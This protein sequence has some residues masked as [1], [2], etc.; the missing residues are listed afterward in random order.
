MKISSYLLTV[1]V[2]VLLALCV[3]VQ[4]RRSRKVCQSCF[5]SISFKLFCGIVCS[6]RFSGCCGRAGLFGR[7]LVVYDL[8][9][10]ESYVLFDALSGEYITRFRKNRAGAWRNI[11]GQLRMPV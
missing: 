5:G 6:G 9:S 1:V 7:N 10:G 11:F 3:G 8:Q 2:G 4:Q